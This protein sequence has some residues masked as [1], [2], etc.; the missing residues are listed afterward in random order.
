MLSGL[1]ECTRK[2]RLSEMKDTPIVSITRVVD[3][4]TGIWANDEFEFS[5]HEDYENTYK[6]NTDACKRLADELRSVADMIE[7]GRI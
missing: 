6:G 1:I 3:D 5:L 7:R 4:D 2:V